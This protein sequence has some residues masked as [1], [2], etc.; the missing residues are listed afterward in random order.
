MRCHLQPSSSQGSESGVGRFRLVPI[1]LPPT[2]HAVAPGPWSPVASSRLGLDRHSTLPHETRSIKRGCAPS[3]L[4]GSWQTASR[5]DAWPAWRDRWSQPPAP[6]PLPPVDM[7]CSP[8]QIC[9]R[10]VHGRSQPS[11]LQ[12]WCLD[13]SISTI[14][15]VLDGCSIISTFDVPPSFYVVVAYLLLARILL[16]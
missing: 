12:L 10:R 2:L 16:P 1:L 8:A 3:R 4:A 7:A 15:L 6:L 9:C 11:S 14:G 5:G 13:T